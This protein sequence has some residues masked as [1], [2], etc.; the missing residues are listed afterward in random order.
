[1]QINYKAIQKNFYFQTY[2]SLLFLFI[3]QYL[4]VMRTS[5]RI[6]R[7]Y[8]LISFLAVGKRFM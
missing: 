5:I 2:A 7:D 3:V 6:L 1:M 8:L 4:L